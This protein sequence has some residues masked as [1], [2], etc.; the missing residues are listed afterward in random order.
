MKG[1]RKH[2]Y[3]RK[4]EKVIPQTAYQLIKICEYCSEFRI[5]F[6]EYFYSDSFGNVLKITPVHYE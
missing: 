2:V 4:E 6:P 3:C 1:D 5:C